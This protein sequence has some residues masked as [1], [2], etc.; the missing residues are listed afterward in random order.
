MLNK[1]NHIK[2]KRTAL[3]VLLGMV[4]CC[5]ISSAYADQYARYYSGKNLRGERKIVLTFDDGPANYDYLC[6]DEVLENYPGY[7]F[8]LTPTENI[9]KILSSYNGILAKDHVKATFFVLGNQLMRQPHMAKIITD[10]GHQLGNHSF[11]H[12]NVLSF[13]STQEVYDEFIKTHNLVLEQT[14]QTMRYMRPPFGSWSDRL[15]E[16]FKEHPLLQDYR[17]PILWNN[18]SFDARYK[19][20]CDVENTLASLKETLR[21]SLGGVVILHDIHAMSAAAL[22]R[23]LAYLKSENE[24]MAS[25]PFNRGPAWQIVP[26]DQAYDEE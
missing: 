22:Y 3:Q 20:E 4:V 6:R 2:G 17:K 10:L 19:K 18:D 1:K 12:R 16:L 8:G 5:L 25:S 14:G 23:L 9:L 15:V 21:F 24:R 26:M 13:E 11:S 7:D